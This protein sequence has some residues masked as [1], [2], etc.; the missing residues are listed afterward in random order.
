MKLTKKLLLA[1]PILILVVFECVYFGYVISIPF[2]EATPSLVF[3]YLLS[4]TVIPFNV[5]HI[6]TAVYVT[7][8]FIYY[9]V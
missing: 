7:F 4:E 6:L 3:S 1:T 5:L 8:I 2:Q 9:D